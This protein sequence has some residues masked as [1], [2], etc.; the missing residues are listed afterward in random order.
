MKKFFVIGNPIDHSLSPKLHNYWFKKNNI[1]AIYDKK[2]LNSDNLK[3]FIS[4]I[5]EKKIFGINVTVPFKKSVIPFLDKLS[6][7]AETTQSVNTIYLDSE[8]IIGHNTDIIGFQNSIRDVN[9]DIK[10]KKILLLGAGGVAPSIIFALNKMSVSKIFVSNRTKEKAENLKDYFENL[11][12]VDWGEI[13]SFDMIIN[14]TSVGLNNDD[15]INLDLS[16]IE[17][18][19]FFYDIIYNPEETEFLKLGKN[20]GHQTENGK[21]MFIYQA[22]ESFHIWHGVK[23]NVDED[24]N[25]ILNQ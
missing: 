13:P 7:E 19:K 12:V 21:K 9:Y 1:E 5:K 25:K 4:G 15:R 20:L 14:A 23:P 2:E 17:K 8:K 16:K 11:I 22:A 6:P 10:D 3:N 24:T 18:G